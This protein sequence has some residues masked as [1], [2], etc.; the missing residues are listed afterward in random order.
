M[1]LDPDEERLQPSGDFDSEAD[2]SLDEESI[3]GLP[4]EQIEEV[5]Q[6]LRSGRRLPPHLFPQ[7]FE[8]P[9]EYELTYAGKSRRAD[10]IADTM[11]VPLQPVRT[12]GPVADGQWS[13]MLIFGDNLQV[14][15][16]LLQMKEAGELR[17]SDGSDGV[18]SSI[19]TPP[20]LLDANS[21]DR[22]SSART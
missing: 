13:D 21:S 1:S 7:L 15:K 22:R 16:R 18:R 2:L 20:L 19:L 8:S 6:L 5:V 9:R 4:E 14:L 12:F 10:V 3:S 17:N 11:A